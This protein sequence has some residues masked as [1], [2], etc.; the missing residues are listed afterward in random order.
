MEILLTPA[1]HATFP[2]GLFGILVARNCRNRPKAAHINADPQ[3]LG[4]RLRRRFPDGQVDL[5]PIAQAYA[6]YF[7]RHGGRYP[8]AHQATS[9]LAGRP[10]ESPSALVEVMFTAEVES[11]VLT[12]GHDL[13]ALSGQLLVDVG[14]ANEVYRKLNGKEQEL[15]PGDMVVRD[16]GGIIA[17]V[18]YGPDART[19]LHLE[20]DSVLFGAWCPA[21]VP[22]AAAT[23]HLEA[24]SALLQQEWPDAAIE[25]WQVLR[26][27]DRGDS[28]PAASTI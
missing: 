11:L 15:T 23:S 21:G 22:V 28:N 19:R 26:S 1:F 20:S 14:H 10:I 27:A 7:R 25:S 18:L 3:A 12:S 17:C 8:V 4:T 24:L 13:S 5:D 16:A 6:A 9:I 2:S